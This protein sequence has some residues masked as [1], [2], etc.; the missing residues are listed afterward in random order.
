MHFCFIPMKRAIPTLMLPPFFYMHNMNEVASPQTFPIYRLLCNL[1][2]IL[3]TPKFQFPML[4]LFPHKQ[5][6]DSRCFFFPHTILLPSGMVLHHYN[7][8]FITL[9]QSIFRIKV[10]WLPYEK[11][12]EEKERKRNGNVNIFY[13][14]ML[15]PHYHKFN[16]NFKTNAANIIRTN[17]RIL[18][19]SN[20]PISFSNIN[21]SKAHTKNTQYLHT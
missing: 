6:K 15:S 1:D 7:E 16:T 4:F 12:V 2:K 5:L 18:L 8:K 21:I 19:T 17:H 13:L 11:P 14:R 9:K 20:K 10:W 3:N